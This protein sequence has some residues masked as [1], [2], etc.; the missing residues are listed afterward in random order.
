MVVGFRYTLQIAS[1]MA[2]YRIVY[3]TI[4]HREHLRFLLLS[5]DQHELRP[6]WNLLLPS[7]V[8]LICEDLDFDL[9]AYPLEMSVVCIFSA[10]S[11]TTLIDN[12]VWRKDSASRLLVASATEA[13]FNECVC[14]LWNN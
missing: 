3:P 11:V 6:L 5:F 9:D 10:R 8:R 7:V 4:R 13:S 2:W 14:D 1:R 12:P